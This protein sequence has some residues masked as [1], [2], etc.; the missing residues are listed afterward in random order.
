[1]TIPLLYSGDINCGKWKTKEERLAQTLIAQFLSGELTDCD[2]GQTCETYLAYKYVLFFR[3]SF[4]YGK[5]PSL[6][7]D[8]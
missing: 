3:L 6:Y 5:A 1:M 2:I 4:W 8:A 7:F